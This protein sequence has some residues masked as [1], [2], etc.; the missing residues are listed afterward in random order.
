MINHLV[1]TSAWIEYFKGNQKYSF[2]KELIYTNTICTNDIILTELLPSMIHRKEKALSEL[3]NRIRKYLLVLDWQDIR[4]IQVLN[5]K[6]GN[7][8]IGISDIII[9][10]NCMQNQLKLITN[11]KHFEAMSKYIPLEIYK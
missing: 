1:D 9:V 8:H 11:D 5:L 3:M 10:Q 4:S 7:N 2:L 6:H